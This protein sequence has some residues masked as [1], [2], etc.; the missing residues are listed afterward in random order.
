MKKVMIALFGVGTLGIGSALYAMPT[1]SNASAS[2]ACANAK[3]GT[4]L[5]CV[6]GSDSC[7]CEAVGVT[8]NGEIVF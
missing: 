4:K 1:V 8:E 2:S 6:C 7:A 5:I 3:N